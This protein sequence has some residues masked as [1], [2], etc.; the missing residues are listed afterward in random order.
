M[1][2]AY[3]VYYFEVLKSL[4][5]KVRRIRAEIFANISRILHHDNAPTHTA[6][7]VR[8]L[9][10]R[11][12]ITVLENPPYSSDLAPQWH[13]SVPEDKEI[14]KEGIFMALMTSGVIRRQL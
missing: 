14:L 11:K 10:A 5:E 8:E 12:Q 1:T 4:R 13:F 7:S 2:F 6:L 3:Q 9:L